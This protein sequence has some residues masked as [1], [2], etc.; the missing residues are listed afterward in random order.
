MICDARRFIA[1]LGLKFER[2][3]PGFE[4][5]GLRNQFHLSSIIFNII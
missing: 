2:T 1:T 3:S 4:V 5:E